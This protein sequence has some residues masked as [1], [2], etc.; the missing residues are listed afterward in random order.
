MSKGIFLYDNIR[1]PEYSRGVNKCF[2]YFI[3]GISEAEDLKV[4][5]FLYT[6]RGIHLPGVK[7]IPYP[8]VLLGEKH[9]HYDVRFANLMA[10]SF[11]KVFYSPYYGQVSTKA[12]QVYTVYDMMYENSPAYFSHDNWK[13]NRVIEEKKKCLHAASLLLCISTN[14]KKDLMEIYPEIPEARIHVI[15]LGVDLS[16][17]KEIKG[18]F[19]GK[20][21][22]LFVGNREGCKNFKRLLTAFANSGLAGN[23]DLRVVSPVSNDFTQAEKEMLTQ[24][25]IEDHVILETSISEEILANR[26]G[27]SHAL[28]SPSEYEGFGLPVLEAMAAGTLVLSSNTA[29]MPEVGGDVPL[30]F[31]PFS[32]EDITRT[33]QKAACLPTDEVKLLQM[34]GKNRASEFTW[35][36]AQQEFV[37]EMKA[38]F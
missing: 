28:I 29:S 38:F 5:K 36:K 6:K 19:D 10:D 2:L 17:Y 12:C 15:P 22:F 7:N 18:K 37:K 8:S 26:Y 30:Y 13:H 32:V 35:K 1:N 9:Y 25:N 27:F 31:D 11:C 4:P 21:Y 3:E 23:F 14:T 33:L 20:P 16:I 34:K 24:L